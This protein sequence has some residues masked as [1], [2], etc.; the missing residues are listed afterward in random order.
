MN[1]DIDR[2]F[3]SSP[4]FQKR[5]CSTS[6]VVFPFSLSIV[7]C[8]FLYQAIASWANASAAN[9]EG[10]VV[11]L[12]ISNHSNDQESSII[13]SVFDLYA[14]IREAEGREVLFIDAR[15]EGSIYLDEYERFTLV[16]GPEEF[17]TIARPY[18]VEVEKHRYIES[19]LHLEREEYPVSPEV[20]YSALKHLQ[21]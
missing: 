7:D 5:Q 10:P 21:V 11:L 16:G 2:R 14:A 19:M 18:P 4:V 8:Y 13:D 12:R 1:D 3:E 9:W 15:S 20:M 17:L 6:N